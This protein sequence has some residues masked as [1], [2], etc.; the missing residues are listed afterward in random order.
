M[1]LPADHA[2]L[3]SIVDLVVEQLVTEIEQGAEM[4]TP[5]GEPLPAG[6]SINS[7]NRRHQHDR[8][9]SAPSAISSQ[10]QP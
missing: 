3:E 7:T 5:T 6:V 10:F 8:H 2:H 4:E 1:A 9:I